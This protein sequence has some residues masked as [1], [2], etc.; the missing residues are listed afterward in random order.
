MRRRFE[1]HVRGC[2]NC[3]RYLE[4][5]RETIRLSGQ[6]ETD[7]LDPGTRA[8]LIALYRRYHREQ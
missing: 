6:I 3:R 5:M 1:R 8:D 4:Q 2:D 7:E